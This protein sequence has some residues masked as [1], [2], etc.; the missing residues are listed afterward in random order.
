[1]ERFG[2]YPDATCP[3]GSTQKS[4]ERGGFYCEPTSAWTQSGQPTPG[5][6]TGHKRTMIVTEARDMTMV[7]VPPTAI[8]YP[9][10]AGWTERSLT[11]PCRP[12]D[13]FASGPN[14]RGEPV[15]YCLPST[16]PAASASASSSAPPGT[17]D[18]IRTKYLAKSAEYDS[19]IQ[20]AL[21]SN[22]STLIGRIRQ[23]NT[24]VSTLLDQMLK[25]LTFAKNDTPLL[26]KERDGLIEKLRRIQLDYNG[27]LVNTDK[28]E[29]LRRIREQEEG[30]FKRDLFR[31]L[32]FFF[33]VC[34][35]I[36]LMILFVKK[37]SQSESTAT[38]AA[39]PRMTP[40]LM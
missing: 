2:I 3:A 23:L 14:E 4:M 13:Y 18:E 26:L 37:G 11:W 36:L 1:M 21:A 38:S 5:C 20:Q 40:P 30:S 35:G 9:V 17:M 6:P 16:G 7:C 32:M 28:L 25:A 24:D 31:Y 19:V 39:T 10:A 22:D 8:S 12:G 27:L 34:V 29:T 15:N 33:I